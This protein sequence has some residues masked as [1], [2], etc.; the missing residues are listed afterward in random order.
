VKRFFVI[1]LT[2][3]L[4]PVFPA[5]AENVVILSEP[6]HRASTGIFFDNELADLISPTGRLGKIVFNPANRGGTWLI[7]PAL[8]EEV[9]DLV[10]GYTYLDQ[11]KKEVVV[12]E[13]VIA[14][15]WI[16]TLKSATRRADVL[17]LP[18]GNPSAS[19]LARSAP[20][21]L[22]LYRTLGQQ[23]LSSL[24]GREVRSTTSTS[25]GAL[26][27]VNG[28]E[29]LSLRRSIA[30][31]N[32][33]ITLREIEDARLKLAQLI[34][35]SLPKNRRTDLSLDLEKANKDLN[36]KIRISG[37]N[38]TI[39]S[40][41]Y[42]LPVTIVN[43]FNQQVNLDVRLSASNA[44]IVIR[45]IPR[46]TVGAQSQ[47]QIKV[48]ITVIAS[49]D[50]TLRIQ[51]WTPGG[52]MVGEMKRIPLRLAVIS[53]STTWFATTL[54]LILLLALVTQSVRRVKLR[55]KIG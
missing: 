44:R 24:L 37:G 25:E 23:R 47:L 52:E 48:P 9:A 39:T 27:R 16:S 10:D 46:I 41:S 2:F 1:L 14:D 50:T 42:E 8:I 22:S 30:T 34:N 38:Y 29:Y 12:P 40:S 5:H 32:S 11:N 18:Y 31:I 7:D 21:E 49:G 28:N 13:L 45:S 3:L 53:S 19:F 6:T 4:I 33:L 36:A 15:I 43:R 51:L 35:P 26:S 17:S 54:A 20:G 55:K